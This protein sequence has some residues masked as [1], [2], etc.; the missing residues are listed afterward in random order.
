MVVSHLDIKYLQKVV[1]K[2]YHD[3]ELERS[4]TVAKNATIQFENKREVLRE[5][6]YYNLDV[7][8]SVGYRVK[9][10]KGVRFWR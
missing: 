10:Q 4:S 8:I 1:Y 3:G 7:I 6:E 5:I 9:S 2:M